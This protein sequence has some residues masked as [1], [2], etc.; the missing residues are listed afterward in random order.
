MEAPPIA[1]PSQI[2][3]ASP[4]AQSD[5]DP[6]PLLNETERVRSPNVRLIDPESIEEG[7]LPDHPCNY[8]KQLHWFAGPRKTPCPAGSK[9][10][11]SKRKREQSQTQ[12]GVKRLPAT[13]CRLCGAFHWYAGRKQT[14][15]PSRDSGALNTVKMIKLETDP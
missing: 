15:C 8:C 12:P 7:D 2:P 3:Y 14:P 10:S 9:M 13:K 4:A 11:K 1:H 6:A 5:T